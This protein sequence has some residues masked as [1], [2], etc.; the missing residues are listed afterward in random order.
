MPEKAESV[1]TINAAALNRA[2]AIEWYAKLML[3]MRERGFSKTEGRAIL[4]EVPQVYEVYTHNTAILTV[5]VRVSNNTD[6]T[7]SL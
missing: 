5:T 3:N 6:N 4:D 1:A 7:V 2:A